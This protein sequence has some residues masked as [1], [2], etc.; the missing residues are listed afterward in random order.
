MAAETVKK[1]IILAISGASGVQ[2]G[3]RL[4]ECLLADG[5]R[6]YLLVSKAAQVVISMETDLEWPASAKVLQEKLC[7]QFQ[8]TREQ[9]RVCGENEWT[10]PIASGSSSTDAMV[11]CPCSMGSLSSIAVGAS[12]NLMERAADVILKERKQLILV[13]REAPFSEIHLEN[14]LKLARMGATILPANPGFYNRPDKVA[15]II[16]FMAARI[17]DHLGIEQ[18]LQPR[19][20]E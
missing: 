12:G 20:G 4:L 17:L 8:V 2:Y 5:H 15:D 13:P 10:S 16:D 14:M 1:T 18:N 6:V 3:A 9:L 7:Q 11:V 19:W